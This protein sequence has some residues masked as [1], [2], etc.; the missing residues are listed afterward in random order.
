[1]NLLPEK[2]Y[3]S[4][5]LCRRTREPIAETGANPAFFLE[6]RAPNRRALELEGHQL[7]IRR[8]R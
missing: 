6:R 7:S 2:F 3:G 8:L 5:A 4:D 1:M